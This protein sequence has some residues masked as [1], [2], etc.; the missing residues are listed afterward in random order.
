MRTR[1]SPGYPTYS[2]VPFRCQGKQ[3]VSVAKSDDSHFS[4]FFRHFQRTG[5]HTVHG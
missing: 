3:R 2:C 5:G 4:E 1:P